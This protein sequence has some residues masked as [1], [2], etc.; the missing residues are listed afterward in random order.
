MN[1]AENIRIDEEAPL[2]PVDVMKKAEILAERPSEV[3]KK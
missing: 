3:R 2:A 1:F